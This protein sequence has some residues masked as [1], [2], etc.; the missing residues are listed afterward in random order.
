MEREALSITARRLRQCREER[1]ETLEQVA[2][3]LGVNKTTVMRWESGSTANISRATLSLLAEHYGVTVG[4]LQGDNTVRPV[5]PAVDGTVRLP[6]LG[7]VKGGFGGAVFEE[8]VGYEPAAASSVRGNEPYCWFTVS[9]DSMTPLINEGDLVL[10]RRQDRVDSG[11]YAV[12]VIDN[13]E[14]T[15]KQIRYLPDGI[16]LHS[17]NPYYPPRRFRGDDAAKVRIVG[18]VMESKRKF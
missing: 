2:A 5:R 9:G 17:V 11:D 7:V 15:V 16:E 8:I 13:E 6:I 14:G 1:R 3:V 18:R 12:A 4:W 10:I